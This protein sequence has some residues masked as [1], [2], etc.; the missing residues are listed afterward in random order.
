MAPPRRKA[1]KQEAP[2][3]LEQAIARIS[4]YRDL[5]DAIDSLQLE[6]SSAVARIQATYD[7]QAKPLELTAR[8]IFLELRAW[9]AV[10]STELT[11]GKRKSIL[12][13]GCS[14]GER[15][16]PPAVSLKK[17]LKMETLL[18]KLEVAGHAIL[19]RVSTKLNKQTAIKSIQ[20]D[21]EIGKWLAEIGVGIRQKEEFFIDWPKPAPADV[22]PDPED[23]T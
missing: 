19:L 12:L 9:W 20:A 8:A 3:T 1:P 16:T 5:T 10:A 15:T 7:E 23:I 17:G 11:E 4:E 21:D 22:V 13:A 2:Q 14:I 18:Q 6:A